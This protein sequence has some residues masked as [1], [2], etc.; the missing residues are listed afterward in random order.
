MEQPSRRR[1]SSVGDA[2]KEAA[3]HGRTRKHWVECV[4]GDVDLG[5]I[6]SAV[7]RRKDWQKHWVRFAGR[8]PSKSRFR[9]PIMEVM[10]V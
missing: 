8:E 3:C 7:Y 2:I 9:L 4:H 5:F 10:M 1:G 6:V